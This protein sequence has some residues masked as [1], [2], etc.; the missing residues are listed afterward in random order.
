ML[1]PPSIENPQGCFIDPAEVVAV[2]AVLTLLRELPCRYTVVLRGG[3]TVIV[4]TDYAE[5]LLAALAERY[6][7]PALKD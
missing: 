2:V 1:V 3:A 7:S 6:S 5:L 4:S